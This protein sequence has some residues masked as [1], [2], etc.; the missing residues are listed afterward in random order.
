[1]LFEHAVPTDST[2]MGNKRV[3]QLSD[4]SL[5]MMG[6]NTGFSRYSGRL[7]WKQL[8]SPN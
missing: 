8:Q 1:V 5:H 7:S 4:Q 3:T 6:T 2:F